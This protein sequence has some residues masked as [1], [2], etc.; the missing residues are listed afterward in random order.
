MHFEVSFILLVSF[1]IEFYTHGFASKK[2][3]QMNLAV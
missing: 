3:F 1:H 2:L